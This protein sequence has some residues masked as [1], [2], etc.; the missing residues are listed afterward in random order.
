[1]S[2]EPQIR[3]CPAQPYAGIRVRIPMDGISAAVDQAFPELF[4]WLAEHAIAPAGR[5]SSATT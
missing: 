2:Q 3:Q 5:R 4:G 1:M